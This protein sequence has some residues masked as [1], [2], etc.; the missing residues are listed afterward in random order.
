MR[1]R[2][3]THLTQHPTLGTRT[4]WLRGTGWDQSHLFPTLHPPP[5]PTAADL[6]TPALHGKYIILTRIDGHCIWVSPAVLSLL[7]SPL[8][9]SPPGGKILGAGSVF[10][11]NAADLVGAVDPDGGGLPREKVLA[12]AERAMR[13]LNRVGVVGVH[14]A[15]MRRGEVEGVR[16]MGEMGVASVRVNAM[17][18]CAVRNTYCGGGGEGGESGEAGEGESVRDLMGRTPNGMLSVYGVKLYADGAL[19]SWG[20][21]LLSPYDD[22]PTSSGTLLVNATALRTLITRWYRAGY[23][24]STHC[25]GD[26]ANHL[27][28]QT[29]AELLP[30]P[31]SSPHTPHAPSP[32]HARRLRIEH[33]QILAPED[34]SLLAQLGIIPSIQP[35][36]ATSDSTYAE[37][38]LGPER[39]RTSAYRMKTL[40]DAPAGLRPV[41]GSDF[42]VES[43]DP[44]VGMYAAVTR[45]DPYADLGG[46]EGGVGHKGGDNGGWYSEEKISV[47]QALEG[48]TRNPAWAM[49]AEDVAGEIARGRWADWVV[50]GYEEALGGHL[51]ARFW[52]EEWLEGGGDVRRLRVLE[53][54]VGG[55]RVFDAKAEEEEEGGEGG[56]GFA[57]AWGWGWGV[58]GWG[59]WDVMGWVQRVFGGSGI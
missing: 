59:G 57:G 15:G 17:V 23:Q 40:F 48:F 34:Q 54:W 7:P 56:S 39:L 55:R 35:S 41:L 31:S 42:P 2:L 33:A 50:L 11:D 28:I 58:A 4:T 46:G 1:S 6:E 10:C 29:Y 44:R 22:N 47:R 21:A 12:R 14:D 38:R 13:A 20:A 26:L 24:I 27:T 9:P 8:P 51:G 3:E 30:P 36:H 25:I 5:M 53:T 43:H 52:E 16:W 45:R 32:N 18:E 37:S 49:W 19:G